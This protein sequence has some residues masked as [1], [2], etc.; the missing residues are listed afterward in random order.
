MMSPDTNR[1]LADKLLECAVLLE[2]QQANPFR[3]R[4]YRQ[5]AAGL[6]RCGADL[7][8]LLTREGRAGLEKLPGVGPSIA[9]AIEEMLR[10]GR[11][12]MLQ[13]L[14][15]TLDAPRLFRTVPGVGPVLAARLHDVL[16][17]DTLEALEVAA[18]DGR[19]ADVP[20]VGERRAAII[21]AGLQ[22]VL[23]RPRGA[24]RGPR[25]EPPV[26][27]LLDVDA[28][29]RRGAARGLLP[30]I[31]PR[32]FN[33]QGQSWLPVLHTQRGPWQFT[34]LFSNTAQAH[35]RGRTHDW[36]VVYFHTAGEP[37]G[38]RTVVTETHG[39]GQG[40][41]VV[42]GR[43]AECLARPAPGAAAGAR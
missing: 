19:L 24:P 20:G 8:A 35:A 42:R 11:W 32:R 38:Q 31:A 2:Q 37:E 30:R 17:V 7:H 3:V 41:R 1:Q 28:E 18:H 15:G 10:T 29:Y 36:V 12:S 16:Q 4:A 13:R 34:A 14:R 9:T 39:A 40:C 43:E 33:P 6:E 27:L 22:A 26:S 21:R 25:R 23:G 5:A